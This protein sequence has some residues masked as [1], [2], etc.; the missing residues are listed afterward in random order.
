MSNNS[1]G[2][3]NIFQELINFRAMLLQMFVIIFLCINMLL[4]VTFFKKECFH[5]SARY[6]LFAVMLLSDSFVLLLSDVLLIVNSL[7]FTI[8]V[9]LCT[10]IS[11]VTV[12]YVMATPVTLTA[13]TLERYVAICLP[14]RHGELC[15]TRRSMHCI[16]IIHGVS[17]VPCIL[18][19]TMFFG[20]ASLGLYKQKA[21][22]SVEVFLLQP[23]Q[24]HF[25]SA[26]SQFYF[27][28]MCIIII[29]C[30]IQIVRV[31]KAASAENKQSTKRG[32]RTVLLHAFQLLLCLIQLWTP[33]SEAAALNV[34]VNLFVDIRFFNYMMFNLAPRCLSPLIYGLRDEKFFLAL[35]N[36]VCLGYCKRYTV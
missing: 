8:Q 3:V 19:L 12:L 16:L 5:T 22:C 14:L 2:V 18:I 4:I 11:V 13:M 34:D 26:V 36:D 1:S 17:S 35:K 15:S 33:F 24:R 28:I 29:F 21:L 25:R 9:W 7:E 27:L 20:T 6:I 10:I 31:A 30:Y 32:L 23:W